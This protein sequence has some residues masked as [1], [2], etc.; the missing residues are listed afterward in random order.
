MLCCPKR[1]VILIAQIVRGAVIAAVINEQKMPNAELAMVGQEKRQTVPFVA[2]RGKA[3]DC[4][5]RY[6]IG[7]IRVAAQLPSFSPSAQ[8]ISAATQSQFISLQKVMRGFD[9]CAP[10]CWLIYAP[11]FNARAAD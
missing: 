8:Q 6:L 9:R 4:V 5:G 1:Y 2:H 11:N 10:S 7:S 3:Q